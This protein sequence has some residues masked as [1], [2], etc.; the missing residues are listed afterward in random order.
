MVKEVDAGEVGD[1]Q[2]SLVPIT[3]PTD[4]PPCQAKNLANEH[5]IPIE[6]WSGYFHGAKDDYVF[7][8]AEDGMNGGLGFS[9][10]HGADPTS[11]FQDAVKFQRDRDR[12]QSIAGDTP[13]TQAALYTRL[14]RP[15]L[16][17]DR[18]RRLLGAHRRR[19]ASAARD[20][21]GLRRGLSAR[22]AGARDRTMRNRPSQERRLHQAGDRR[23]E[24]RRCVAKRDRLR[25]RGAD[26]ATTDVDT[27]GGWP[28]GPL[29]CR[30]THGPQ[31][32]GIGMKTAG[33]PE[34][35]TAA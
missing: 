5:V 7:L 10:Y 12:F 20:T 24:G 18:G 22:E 2:I 28:R 30:L 25:C 14:Y 11:L 6:S 16:R 33:V 35:S 13:E 4:R 19:D 15:L 3:S 32:G 9:V 26:P 29:A 1:E 34:S 27:A 31:G 21:A 23:H 17:T 8:S